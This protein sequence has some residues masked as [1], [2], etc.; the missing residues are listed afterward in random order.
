MPTEIAICIIVTLFILILMKLHMDGIFKMI[1]EYL[2][3]EK[4]R[5]KNE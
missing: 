5:D 1:F 3:D 2:K 4:E